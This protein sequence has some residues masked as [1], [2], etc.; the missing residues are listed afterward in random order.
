MR[1]RIR[2]I[3]MPAINAVMGGSCTTRPNKLMKTITSP[4]LT[5]SRE[6]ILCAY[7]HRSSLSIELRVR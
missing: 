5:I 2:R 7:T 6:E 1:I 3:E 4:V